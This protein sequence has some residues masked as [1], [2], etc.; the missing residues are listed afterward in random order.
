LHNVYGNKE[1][2]INGTRFPRTTAKVLFVDPLYNL[3]FVEAPAGV[4][5]PELNLR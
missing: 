3:A 1:V 2:L 4:I 5:F